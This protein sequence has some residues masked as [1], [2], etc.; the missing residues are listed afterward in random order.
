MKPS[1][2]NADDAFL[3]G[4]GA[5]IVDGLHYAD[6]EKCGPKGVTTGQ[7]VRVVVQ[8]IDSQPAR[9]HEDFKKLTVEAM[10]KARPCQ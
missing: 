8:Y 2:R 7:M 6:V 5:G 3:Q 10:R 4:V 1:Y 9:L